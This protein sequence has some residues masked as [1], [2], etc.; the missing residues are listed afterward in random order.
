V[1]ALLDLW[2]EPA[3]ELLKWSAFRIRILKN[4][5]QTPIIMI[6]ALVSRQFVARFG[7]EFKAVAERAGKSVT[8]LTL[9]EEQG[10]RLSREDCER[11]D[12]IFLDRDIRFHEQLYAAYREAVAAAKNVKWAHYTS[13]GVGQQFYATELDARGVTLTTSTGSNAEPVAQTGFTGLLML[14]RGF[15][16]YIQGQHRHEWRPL[17]GAALPDDLRGQTLLLIGGGAVGTVFAGY[18][19]AFGLKVI[20]VRRSPRKPEDPVDELHLPSELPELLPRADWIVIACPLTK[21]TR[22]LIDADAFARMRKGARLIN[23]GR[24]EVVDEEALI[25]AL[26][27]GRLAGAALDAHRQE[28]L[29]PDSPLWDLP[30][31]IISPHN[32]SASSGNE[33]RCAEMFVANFGHWVRGEPMFNVQHVT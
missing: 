10:A 26:S 24:G 30:N 31:V 3:G 28:P 6:T 8:F 18:A 22:N 4:A 5:T 19:R 11:I 1:R 27:N 7:D 2:T 29:P 16:T 20:G 15:P 14:A 21:D 13:S 33:K 25:E 9:P 32:A 23:I 12:C 17:R